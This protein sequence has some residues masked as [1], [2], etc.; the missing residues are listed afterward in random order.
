MFTSSS[1]NS[2]LLAAITRGDRPESA[3]RL[4]TSLHH[5]SISYLISP[6]FLAE[7]ETTLGLGDTHPHFTAQPPPAWP[8]PGSLRDR[9]GLI[10]GA[11]H[12]H[13]LTLSLKWPPISSNSAPK[14]SRNLRTSKEDPSYAC[15]RHLLILLPIASGIS[16]QPTTA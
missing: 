9:P 14:G 6:N 4:L 5:R 2:A 8:D 11:H 1:S 3:R 16:T 10:R 7:T 15:L 12:W 13:S